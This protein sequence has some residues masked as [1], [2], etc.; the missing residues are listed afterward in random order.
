MEKAS[1]FP[2]AADLR[3]H[4]PGGGECPGRKG[5]SSS[6]AASRDEARGAPK[7]GIHG[8]LE[9]PRDFPWAS[10]LGFPP[11]TDMQMNDQALG[12]IFDQDD[13]GVSNTFLTFSAGE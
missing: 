1:R 9:A 11:D 12:L 8:L 5:L 7:R 3:E 6:A 10:C 2:L 4:V 13:V